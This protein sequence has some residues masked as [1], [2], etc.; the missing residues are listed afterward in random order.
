MMNKEGKII[1]KSRESYGS[2]NGFRIKP[3]P[4]GQSGPDTTDDILFI[5]PRVVSRGNEIFVIRNISPVA[6]LFARAK[7]YT[8]GEV[9][10]LI[11]NGAV[12][13]ETWKSKEIQGYLADF[14][15]ASLGRE[16]ETVLVVALQYPKEVLSF[17]QGSSA[18]MVSR[19]EKTN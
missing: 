3:N 8:R 13:Q 9:Q 4:T 10:R 12:L 7:V 15:F 17:S 2:A 5:N 14:Q 1:W 11:W 18:L 19:L 16:G 6:D